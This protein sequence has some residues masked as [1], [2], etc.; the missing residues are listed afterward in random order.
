[1]STPT[2]E[3]EE[4]Y[5]IWAGAAGR[6]DAKTAE[7]TGIPRR[8]IAHWRVT[9]G[10]RERYLSVSSE[11]AALIARTAVVSMREGMGLVVER[12][13]AIVG[14]KTP[15]R[16]ADGTILVD[17]ETGETVMTWASKD[18]DA[19]KAGQLLA[20]YALGPAQTTAVVDTSLP[21][22]YAVHTGQLTYQALPEPEDATPEDLQS[23]R[24]AAAQMLEETAMSVNTRV[25]P[26]RR[27]GERI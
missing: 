7:L 6:S 27:R 25:E 15:V 9:Q 11:D 10:W 3:R 23:L 12:L 18:G 8:T 16:K 2:P 14:D 20:Q 24:Q 21:T 13:V 5:E 22:T 19:I 26:G 1:M 4:A 17:P